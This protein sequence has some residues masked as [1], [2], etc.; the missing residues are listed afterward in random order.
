MGQIDVLRNVRGSGAFDLAENARAKQDGII[1]DDG[2]LDDHGRSRFRGDHDHF[3]AFAAVLD[4]RN[5]RGQAGSSSSA[6]SAAGAKPARWWR[7]VALWCW[8][9]HPWQRRRWL[10]VLLTVMA[11]SVYFYR[12]DE[13]RQVVFDEVHFGGFASHYIRRTFFFDVHPPVGKLLLAL[14]GYLAGYDGSFTFKTIGAPP[15]AQVATLAP[16]MTADSLR[17]RHGLCARRASCPLRGHARCTCSHGQL[18]GSNCISHHARWASL[19]RRC[20]QSLTCSDAEL[21]FSTHGAVLVA[22]LFML[23]NAFVTQ[24][25]FILLDGILMFFIL[26]SLYSCVRL[27]RSMDGRMTAAGCRS[28]KFRNLRHRAFSGPWWFWLLT[29]GAFLGLA[30]SVKWVG[31][32]VIALVRDAD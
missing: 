6:S 32:F 11:V 23:E 18:A 12:I 21:G 22:V 19:S 10:L 13:P 26:C 27:S 25:R 20:R 9:Q 1:I 8:P 3:D 31:L 7:R 24:C 4:E 29:T 16:S 5:G 15:S 2:G 14:A 30:V 28:V 17:A